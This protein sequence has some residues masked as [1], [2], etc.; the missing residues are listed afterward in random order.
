MLL[1]LWSCN[2]LCSSSIFH[3]EQTPCV[4]Q[5]YCFYSATREV[6]E[7]PVFTQSYQIEHYNLRCS[8]IG[9]TFSY[10]CTACTYFNGIR[11]YHVIH[12]PPP[13]YWI[14]CLIGYAPL[15][16]SVCNK[17]GSTTTAPQSPELRAFPSPLLDILPDETNLLHPMY[18]Q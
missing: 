8:T 9:L 5:I 14:T 1:E 11:Y 7:R 4:V 18:I 15:V 2:Y 16:P 12:Y 6:Y 17:R 13:A 10:T 3:N